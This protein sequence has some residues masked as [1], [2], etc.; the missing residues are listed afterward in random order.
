MYIH[1]ECNPPLWGAETSSLI[2][3]VSKLTSQG[4]CLTVFCG[5]IVVTA[6]LQMRFNL[7][8]GYNLSSQEGLASSSLVHM[9]Q[10]MKKVMIFIYNHCL[11][12]NHCLF[13]LSSITIQKSKPFD[14]IGFRKK[15]C[16]SHYILFCHV[17]LASVFSI[18][19][20]QI[21]S[22]FLYNLSFIPLLYE[23]SPWTVSVSFVCAWCMSL[24]ELALECEKC[25]IHVQFWVKIFFFKATLTFKNIFKSSRPPV[26]GIHGGENGA[27]SIALS[28]GYEDD[29]DLGDYFTYTGEG[30]Y[31]HSCEK[32]FLPTLEKVCTSIHVNKN[33]LH[34]SRYWKK[35]LQMKI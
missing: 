3:K 17:Q 32:K 13:L 21:R 4:S 14:P 25:N 1:I 8:N 24:M 28:G 27:Y 5:N 19:I 12:F 2:P 31:K 10:D 16:L 29:V 18:F 9:S 30:L 35:M 26:A 6:A 23:G 22:H 11:F 7:E 34:P 20:Y 15:K 33:F